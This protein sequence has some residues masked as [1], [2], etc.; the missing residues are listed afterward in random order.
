MQSQKE[1]L[2]AIIVINL[3][4]L[5]KF[6]QARM[7]G[8]TLNL[9]LLVIIFTARSKD[10]KYMSVDQEWKTHLLHLEWRD[11]FTIAKCLDIE[12]MNANHRKNLTRQTIIHLRKLVL[13]GLILDVWIRVIGLE[14]RTEQW[15]QK[16]WRKS[17][18]WTN[19]EGD[20]SNLEDKSGN[21][22][23]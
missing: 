8:K 21:L 4:T 12:H 14:H 19:K 9:S 3:Y 11:I 10:I 20:E 7:V 16:C 1:I 17:G 5:K 13:I 22:M 15:T 6:A 2:H 18:Y 23:Q